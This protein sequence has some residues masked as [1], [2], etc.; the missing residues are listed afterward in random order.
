MHIH[1]FKIAMKYL[2]LFPQRSVKT[3]SAMVQSGLPFMCL[4][5]LRNFADSWPT[6]RGVVNA[7]D[8]AIAMFILE[9][10]SWVP[11]LDHFGA[12]DI[13]PLA[14]GAATSQIHQASMALH[15][16]RLF[17]EACFTTSG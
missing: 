9:S 1:I 2:A 10:W 6:I 16:T 12:P 14:L 7:Y 3:L 17:F 5:P 15:L 4:F 8:N 11:R 13:P